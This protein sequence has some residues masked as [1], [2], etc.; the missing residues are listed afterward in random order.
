MSSNENIYP[1]SLLRAG[2]APRLNEEEELIMASAEQPTPPAPQANSRPTRKD[3]AVIRYIAGQDGDADRWRRL[4][5]AW[6]ISFAIHIVLFGA[7]LILNFR[8]NAETVI[9][10]Y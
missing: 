1:R 8:L 2:Q 6:I 9:P 3:P 10:D 5:P 4:L 7:F